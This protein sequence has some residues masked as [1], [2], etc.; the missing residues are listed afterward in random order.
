M[1]KFTISIDTVMGGYTVALHDEI[2]EVDET[3]VA[4]TPRQAAK[5][6]GDLI[7]SALKGE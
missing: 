4:A 3:A 7:E 6:A 5:R 1:K 2:G